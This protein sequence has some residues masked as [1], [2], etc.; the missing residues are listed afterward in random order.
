MNLVE[1]QRFKVVVSNEKDCI[2][3]SKFDHLSF[4]KSTSN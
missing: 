3:Y 1:I 2:W 4:Y